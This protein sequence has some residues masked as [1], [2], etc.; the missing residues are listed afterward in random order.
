MSFNDSL[1]FFLSADVKMPKSMI[2]VCREGCPR[3][4]LDDGWRAERQEEEGGRTERKQARV[5]I[6]QVISSK[7]RS[8]SQLR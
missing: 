3:A 7:K 2:V 5:V 6:Y 8:V 1:S 4:F